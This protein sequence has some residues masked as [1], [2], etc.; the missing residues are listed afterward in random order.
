M[1]SKKPT[2]VY[3][4]SRDNIAPPTKGAHIYFNC[5]TYMTKLLVL[6]GGSRKHICSKAYKTIIIMLYQLWPHVLLI[7]SPFDL[8]W[9]PFLLVKSSFFMVKCHFSCLNLPCLLDNWPC[10]NPSKKSSS[11]TGD[12][13]ARH[14]H[15]DFAGFWWWSLW[16]KHG[17]QSM[18]FMVL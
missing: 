15:E 9:S 3:I 1:C 5:S 11:T 4:R 10:S 17:G 18:D 6:W 7:N 16:R 8:V 12:R 14:G 13:Q 2:K